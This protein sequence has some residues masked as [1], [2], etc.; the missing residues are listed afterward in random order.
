MFTNEIY[1]MFLKGLYDCKTEG[2]TM[3]SSTNECAVYRYIMAHH[4]L[5]NT[6]K[7]NSAPPATPAATE[8]AAPEAVTVFF[9]RHKSRRERERGE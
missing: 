3:M 8:V 7:K 1:A 5:S 9:I 2:D 6:Q 4:Y